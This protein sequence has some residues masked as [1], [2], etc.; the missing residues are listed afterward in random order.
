MDKKGIFVIYGGSFNP[1]LNSHF[2]LAE[3]VLNNVEGVEK[4][5]FVPVN[6]KYNRIT[7]VEDKHRYNML[8]SV[9]KEN[10]DFLLSTVEMERKRQLK[11]I[12]TMQIFKKEF[13]NKELWFMLGVDNLK[14]L[15]TWEGAEELVENFKILVLEGYKTRITS[16]I[17]NDDFL[18]KYEDRFIRLKGAIMTNIESIYVRN[19]LKEGKGVKFLIPEKVRSYIIENKLYI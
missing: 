10:K 5:I 6:R 15:S 13:P 8:M 7:L 1:P 4:I 19:S 18:K 3:Y 17:R 9:I 12:E 11:T 14:E 16:V 2:S